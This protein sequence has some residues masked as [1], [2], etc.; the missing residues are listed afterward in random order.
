MVLIDFVVSI[1]QDVAIFHMMERYGLPAKEEV[2][3]E[4]MTEVRDFQFVSK[5]FSVNT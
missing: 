3:T 5:L 2:F 4:K 1:F